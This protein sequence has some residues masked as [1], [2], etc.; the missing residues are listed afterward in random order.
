MEGWAKGIIL[1]KMKNKPTDQLNKQ[2]T[3]KNLQNQNRGK[4]R[5]TSNA[6]AIL[7]HHTKNTEIPSLYPSNNFPL[8]LL[9]SMMLCEIEYPFC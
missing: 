4:W 3:N 1:S 9:M 7:Q 8:V 5:K 2:A 6:K